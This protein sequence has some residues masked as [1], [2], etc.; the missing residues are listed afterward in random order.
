MK[1]WIEIN[2]DVNFGSTDKNYATEVYVGGREHGTDPEEIM[3]N[4]EDLDYENFERVDANI[5]GVTV[6]TYRKDNHDYLILEMDGGDYPSHYV[7][8]R[9]CHESA[10]FKKEL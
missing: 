2:S 10:P 9:Q 4:K 3:V 8:L 1:D 5:N 6:Y 7:T